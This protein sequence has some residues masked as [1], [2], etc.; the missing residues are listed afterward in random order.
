[1][2]M[3][4]ISTSW[5]YQP[6]PK[7]LTVTPGDGAV[8]P[9]SVTQGSL[10]MMSSCRSMLPL[11]SKTITRG[12]SDSSAARSD[13]V[14][15]SFRVVTVSTAGFRPHPY[16]ARV[17]IPKPSPPGTTTWAETLVARTSPQSMATVRT[18]TRSVAPATAR[19]TRWSFGK[20][21][22]CRRTIPSRMKHLL[23]GL[24]T[25]G[26]EDEDFGAAARPGTD[27]ERRRGCRPTS[28]RRARQG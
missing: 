19:E 27:N 15:S 23:V 11:V 21:E 7:F 18:R 20:R 9:A 28:G 10:T 22:V 16:A 1:M 3:C 2:R 17:I 26:I 14:P 6:I 4:C 25:T 5:V 24:S 12:R 13:P 8:C